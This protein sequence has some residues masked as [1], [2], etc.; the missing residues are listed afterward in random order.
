MTRRWTFYNPVSDILLFGQKICGSGMIQ[1][2]RN[3]RG[4]PV[5]RVAF[6]LDEDL[7]RCCNIL[8]KRI[9]LVKGHGSSVLECL[10]GRKVQ[11]SRRKVL[12]AVHR[13]SPAPSPSFQRGCS[14]V[15]EIFV[16]V[17]SQVLPVQLGSVDSST[18][19]QLAD[20][21]D[22]AIDELEFRDELLEQTSTFDAAKFPRWQGD[23]EPR[24]EF[25]S[26]NTFLPG[27]KMEE[28]VLSRENIQLLKR[29]GSPFL[30]DVAS[31]TG[32]KIKFLLNSQGKKFSDLRGLSI[33]GTGEAREEAKKAVLA[34]LDSYSAFAAENP[35]GI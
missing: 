13:G 3:N 31:K 21:H 2:F 32:C 11:P 15:K 20:V 23:N 12:A 25:I 29:R 27:E 28:M 14:G 35:I 8:R 33:I 4:K 19:Y 24:L 30:D 16:V 5:P 9:P 1:F 10:H 17:P 7:Q 26:L 22:I 6:M 34:E 18:G